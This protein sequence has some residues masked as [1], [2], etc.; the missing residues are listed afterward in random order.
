MRNIRNVKTMK[1][2]NVI[3]ENMAHLCLNV[4]TTDD[5][6]R[7]KTGELAELLALF[8]NLHHKINNNKK[9]M[10]EVELYVLEERKS[11]IGT[12]VEHKGSKNEQESKS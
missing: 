11:H 1:E 10:R 6:H 12:H 2:A 9:K 5:T 8:F 3:E 4:L 7:V